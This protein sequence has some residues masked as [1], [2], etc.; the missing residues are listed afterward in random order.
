MRG[1]YDR[2]NLAWKTSYVKEY[3]FDIRMTFKCYK[4]TD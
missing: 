1:V 4:N 3:F 2:S